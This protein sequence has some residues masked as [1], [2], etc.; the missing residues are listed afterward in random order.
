[1][2]D[3]NEIEC[4]Y[5]HHKAHVSNFTQAGLNNVY[6][7][8]RECAKQKTKKYRNLHRQKY[9]EKRREYNNTW[10]RNKRLKNKQKLMEVT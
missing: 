6:K 8:C 7:I 9:N 2:Q 5:R 4:Q 10:Q 3:N 1:M